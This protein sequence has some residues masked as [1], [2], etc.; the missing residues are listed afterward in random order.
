[1]CIAALLILTATASAAHASTARTASAL[2]LKPVD[3]GAKFYTRFSQGLPA[4]PSYFPIGVWFES[5]L[6]QADI[7]KDRDA[8]LNTY[9]VLTG[10]S[11]LDLVR[12]NGMHAIVGSDLGD[13]RAIGGWFLADEVDMTHGPSNGYAEMQRVAAATPDDGRLR[14][15]G[16][17]KGV[18]FWESDAEA[19]RF[20]IHYQDIVQA[21]AYFFTD[22]DVCDSSQAGGEPGIVETD[23]CHV[24]S[25]YG[26]IIDRLQGLVSPPGSEPVW[27]VVEVGHPF[28]EED[29]PSITP[30][31]IRAAVW[32]S[33]IAG[34]RGIIYFNHSFGGP[35]PTQHALREP[36]YAPQRAV[37]RA[38]N[39]QI[40]RLAPVLNSPIVGS[41]WSQ[42]AGTTAMVKWATGKK[43]AKNRCK[44][45]K[46]C[47]KAEGKKSAKKRCK[48][49]KK[50][51]NAKGQ[52][53]VFAGSEGSSVQ[54]RFS[55][56][57]VSD[58]KAAVVGENRTVP[59]RNGSF[60]DHFADGNAIH[61]YRINV[62]S[63]CGP[64]R[65]GR[66]TPVG[67]PRDSSG[68]GDP[69]SSSNTFPLII[70]AM[71]VLVGILGILGAF[72]INRSPGR[73][74]L[75]SGKRAKRSHHVGT[76]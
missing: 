42:G 4:K 56:P 14:Y 20:V 7:D 40:T 74:N 27:A 72:G 22:N 43:S 38:T 29:W 71:V 17:G 13:H 66:A 12:S 9:L 50:C 28:S 70:A 58:A 5:V 35:N 62:G 18:L 69:A 41:G 67:L 26:W 1:V 30:P 59:V 34:A 76:R 65:Q 47:K 57:C 60:S 54:G 48:K 25:N 63:R 75:R 15:S 11:N 73:L 37:V 39:A 6:S 68:R 8:G 21:D 55:L 33:I 53:Y 36:A 49:N 61:I 46:K 52:L 24:A 2:T 45:N 44:K 19:A 32:Q 10:N 51:K 64:S 31:Q 23:H 3:G 16:Y